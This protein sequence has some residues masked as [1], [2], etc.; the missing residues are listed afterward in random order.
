MKIFRIIAVAA[1]LLGVAACNDDND[2]RS[3]MQEEP[4]FTATVAAVVNQPASTAEVVQPVSLAVVMADS[5]ETA[6]PVAISF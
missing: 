6:E 4:S 5:S 3:S 1:T 2:R